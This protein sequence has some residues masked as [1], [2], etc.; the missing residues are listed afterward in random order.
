[1]S[2]LCRITLDPRVLLGED[3][4]K[5]ARGW[6]GATVRDFLREF[7]APADPSSFPIQE[8]GETQGRTCEGSVVLPLKVA[9]AMVRASG[10]ELGL[11]GPH[12]I[13]PLMV[14]PYMN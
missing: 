10:R 4:K 8:A 2:H 9:R 11:N 1:M 5:G 3:S 7:V 12:M 14:V 13:P 6:T